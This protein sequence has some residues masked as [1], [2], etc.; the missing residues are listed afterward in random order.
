MNHPV[1]WFEVMGE[2]AAKLQK[3]YRD[4]FGWKI[5]ADNPMKYGMVEAG[6]VKGTKSIPGGVGQ[7][8]PGTRSGV[9]FYV[10]TPNIDKTLA[11]VTKVGGKVLIGKKKPEMGPVMAFIQDPEGHVIGLVEHE[12]MPA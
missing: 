2:D 9:T 6:E 12:D 10:D 4:L 3:F 8:T 5:D 7:T 11:D 1:V